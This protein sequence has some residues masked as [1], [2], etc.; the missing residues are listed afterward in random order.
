MSLLLGQPNSAIKAATLYCPGRWPTVCRNA[1]GH[2]GT[3]LQGHSGLE[4]DMLKLSEKICLN[5][6]EMGFAGFYHRK[7]SLWEF[8][9]NILLENVRNLLDFVRNLFLYVLG[10]N[11]ADIAKLR[12]LSLLKL[13]KL[14]I[15]NWPYFFVLSTFLLMK[16]KSPIVLPLM[17]HYIFLISFP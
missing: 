1:S 8:V 7:I 14:K 17:P 16:V 6:P 5:V 12:P 13:L 11:N 15:I 3:F 4:M 9:R 10:I 2:H